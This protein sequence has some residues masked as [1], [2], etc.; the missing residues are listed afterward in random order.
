MLRFHLTGANFGYDELG[1]VDIG[2]VGIVDRSKVRGDFGWR[3][4][5]KSGIWVASTDKEQ[6][7]RGYS[8]EWKRYGMNTRVEKVNGSGQR[9]R[10][11]NLL[12]A[13]QHLRLSQG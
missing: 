3:H 5:E 11:N 12:A 10:S 4:C 2:G 1:E 6:G 7:K 13:P 9:C 8:L